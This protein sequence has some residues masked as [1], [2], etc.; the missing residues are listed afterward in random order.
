MPLHKLEWRF[1]Y[2]VK[3][4]I[5]LLAIF[6]K[7]DSGSSGRHR[8][9]TTTANSSKSSKPKRLR[10]AITIAKHI[11]TT[12][13]FRIKFFKNQLLLFYSCSLFFLSSFLCE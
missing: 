5:T 1:F 8:A 9:K 12:T 4:S 7:I 10:I 11:A 3:K 13:G 2:F 6:S